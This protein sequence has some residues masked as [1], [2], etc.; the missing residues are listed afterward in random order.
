MAPPH[1]LP[2]LMTH[3]GDVIASHSHFYIFVLTLRG[4]VIYILL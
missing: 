2:Q 4:K 1:F 3:H